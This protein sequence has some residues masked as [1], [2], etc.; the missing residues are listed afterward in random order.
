VHRI[1]SPAEPNLHNGAG[2]TSCMEAVKDNAG[3]ELELSDGANTGLNP[4]GGIKCS[5]H[6]HGE[7]EWGERAAINANSLT[8]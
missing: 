1:E 4:V 3:K 2:N 8:V 5:L 6:R 7:W